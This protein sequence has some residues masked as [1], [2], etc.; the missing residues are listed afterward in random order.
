MIPL[1]R[2]SLRPVRQ[3]RECSPSRDVASL[4]G[5]TKRDGVVIAADD[6]TPGDAGNRVHRS[7]PDSPPGHG[8]FEQA[9]GDADHCSSAEFAPL[10]QHGSLR[11]SAMAHAPAP[12]DW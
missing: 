6:Q 11:S 3:V 7:R 4:P 10:W 1:R 8:R 9:L 2:F 5:H 12:S